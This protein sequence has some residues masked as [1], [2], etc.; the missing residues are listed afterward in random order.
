MIPVRYWR[1]WHSVFMQDVAY[2]HIRV[3]RRVCDIPMI[4]GLSNRKSRTPGCALMYWRQLVPNRMLKRCFGLLC[5]KRFPD[6]IFVQI[7]D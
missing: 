7:V 3:Q 4:Y 1:C 5:Q 6:R 2:E